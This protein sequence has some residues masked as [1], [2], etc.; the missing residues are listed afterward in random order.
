MKPSS[1]STEQG[2]A[3]GLI[4]VIGLIVAGTFSGL[5]IESNN[6]MG[7]AELFFGSPPEAQDS[8]S[9]SMRIGTVYIEIDG[10]NTDMES[11]CSDS[12]YCFT[13]DLIET[14]DFQMGSETKTVS[15]DKD[16]FQYKGLVADVANEN[17]Y[18]RCSRTGCDLR[19]QSSVR[20]GELAVEVNNSYVAEELD[21]EVANI[22]LYKENGVEKISYD[23]N[24]ENNWIASVAGDLSVNF[25]GKQI[26]L[27][28]VEI[29]SGS[30]ESFEV[31]EDLTNYDQGQ[32]NI[33]KTSEYTVEYGLSNFHLPGS[34]LSGN[35]NLNGDWQDNQYSFDGDDEWKLG[36]LEND[37]SFTSLV[38]S[39]LTSAVYFVQG[40]EC[41]LGEFTQSEMPDQQFDSRTS[42]ESYLEKPEETESVNIFTAVKNWITGLFGGL[43]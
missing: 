19:T 7:E 18:E 6:E 26:D 31:E 28:S 22:N 8:V 41:M 24:V 11:E 3:A 37:N 27:D 1:I 29:S 23:V 36:S 30:V 20:F 2:F 12:Q 17:W 33:G 34:D 42:C 4:I 25:A 38:E 21:L 32:L 40:G 5:D 16:T 13:S 15:K 9:N 35:P 14:Y 10:S 43:L 39:E